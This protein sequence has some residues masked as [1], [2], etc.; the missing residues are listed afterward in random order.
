MKMMTFTPKKF[1]D[2]LI[3]NDVLLTH[4]VKAGIDRNYFIPRYK[5]DTRKIKELT[6]DYKKSLRFSSVQ[7]IATLLVESGFFKDKD[8][9]ISC[10]EIDDFTNLIP[11]DL[12]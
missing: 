3:L 10:F 8:L 6:F 1:L 2:A 7:K 12:L 4:I 11:R 9:I 5:Q